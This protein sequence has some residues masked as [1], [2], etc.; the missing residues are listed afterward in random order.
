ML[1]PVR[2]GKHDVV[3]AVRHLDSISSS[4]FSMLMARMPTERGLPNSDNT[5]LLHDA[6]ARREEQELIFGELADRHEGGEPL[7]GLHRD[8]VQDRLPRAARARWGISWTLS[9]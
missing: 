1:M 7:V 9:Q 5:V 8:A 6:L 3:L 4:P 2:G